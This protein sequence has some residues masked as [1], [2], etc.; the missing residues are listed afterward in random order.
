MQLDQLFSNIEYTGIL[1]E[2]DISTVTQDSRRVIEG[3]V[4]VCTKGNTSDGHD[5]AQMAVKSGAALIVS[6]WPTGADNEIIVANT[7]VVYAQLCQAFFENPAKKLRLVAVTGTNGKTTVTTLLKQ[8]IEKSG[9]KAG[10]IG[11]I[12]TEIDTMDVP[13]KYTTPEPWDLAALMSRMCSAGCTFAILE[14]S[15]QALDQLRLWGIEFEVGVFTNLTQDHLD[16]HKTFENYFIAKKSLF[17][18]VKTKVINIDD[19]YGK[20]VLAECKTEKTLTVSAKDDT[21][22]YTARDIRLG[23]S[24]VQFVMV[25]NGFISR[26]AF[27]MPGEYSVNNALCAAG[28]AIAL[29]IQPQAACEALASSKGVRGRCEVL[30]GGKFTVL[31]DYAHTGDAIEKVLSGIAPFTTGRLIVLYGC[32]GER[33]A[34]KRPLMSQAVVKYAKIAVLTSDN[35]RKENP[36]DIIADAEATLKVS[37]I[38]YIVEVERRTAL[39]KALEL[40]GDGD[41]LVLCGKG[42]E[43]YQVIDGVTLYLDEHRIVKDWLLENSLI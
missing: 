37:G 9:Y 15:S 39:R 42:H 27:P 33:D 12:H 31:C 23:A 30:Y 38:D 21:A 10:L 41:V 6:Q 3:A 36:Y 34:K 19:E 5:F 14:A 43:D 13:A 8:I 26:I 25:G 20:R 28:A 7:R 4:F 32:A 29:G 16:Y 24:G 22:D 18:Q 11:T 17:N 1:P 35:P 2:Y 40:C